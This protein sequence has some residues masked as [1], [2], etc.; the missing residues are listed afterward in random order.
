MNSKNDR[1]AGALGEEYRLCAMALPW[2]DEAED[3]VRD[4][5]REFARSCQ[6]ERIE[7]L[8]V[9]CGTGYT[10]QRLIDADPRVHVTA[11]DNEPV[12]IQQA[13]AVFAD[14]A[15]RVSFHCADI[16]K[17]LDELPAG[18]VD[19]IASGYALHNFDPTFR[20]AFFKK[21]ARV[22]RPGGLFVNMDKYADDDTAIH[23]KNFAAEVQCYSILDTIGRSDVRLAWE[24]HYAE[25]EL[26]KFTEDE[27]L[28]LLRQ[29]QFSDIQRTFHKGMAATF[30]AIKK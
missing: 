9:G 21:I 15:E 19:V 17:M 30:V 12:M 6:A 24:A 11:V 14:V 18:S 1:F 7:V 2:Y 8:E 29:N 22:V 16:M 25:D 27:Q 28:R 4:A 20:A 26:I 3:T 13:Q 23:E 10:T 5:V